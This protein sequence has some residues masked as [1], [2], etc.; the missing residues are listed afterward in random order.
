MSIERDN[1]E[2]MNYV[3]SLKDAVKR[4]FAVDYLEWIRSGR[5]GSMPS[6]GALPPTLA[7]AVALNLDALG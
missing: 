5:S 4:R 6:R 7:K 3:R 2:G 1:S